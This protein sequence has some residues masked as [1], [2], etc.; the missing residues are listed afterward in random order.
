MASG[1]MRHNI[2]EQVQEC[3][4]HTAL[5]SRHVDDDTRRYDLHSRTEQGLCGT[6]QMTT[7]VTAN[8]GE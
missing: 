8:E 3:E 4:A 6:Q 7:H 2:G 5:V 1:L